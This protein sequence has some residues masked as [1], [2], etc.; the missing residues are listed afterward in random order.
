M[1]C[2]KTAVPMLEI[3]VVLDPERPQEGGPSYWP[4]T[5]MPL[6]IETKP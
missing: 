2:A 6:S 3:V 5:L 1:F 4:Y